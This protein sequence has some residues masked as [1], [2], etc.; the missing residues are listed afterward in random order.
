MHMTGQ[1]DSRALPY[2]RDGVPGL[3]MA[4]QEAMLKQA[5]IDLEH[6]TRDALGATQLRRREPK[7]LK[8]RALLLHLGGR[9]QQDLASSLTPITIYVASLRCLGWNVADIARALAAAGRLGISVHAVDASTTYAANVLDPGLLEALAD[10][11]ETWRRGQTKDGRTAAV[12]VI[13]AKAEVARRAKLEMARP[14]WAKPAG[15]I[16]GAEIAKTVGV[17]LRSLN[18]WLGPRRQVRAKVERP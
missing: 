3:T 5:R 11:D 4:E 8:Q 10:A 16:S 7:S 1:G 18:Q 14:L 17:S 12:A 9:V 15:E 2:V 6:I 13:T